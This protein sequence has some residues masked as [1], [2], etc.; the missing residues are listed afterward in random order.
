MLRRMAVKNARLLQG[1]PT[2]IGLAIV[3]CKYVTL[4]ACM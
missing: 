2:I 3:P 1:G 4:L